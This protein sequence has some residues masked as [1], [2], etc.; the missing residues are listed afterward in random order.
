M[1]DQKGEPVFPEKIDELLAQKIVRHSKEATD[2]TD[3]NTES[4]LAT[5]QPVLHHSGHDFSLLKKITLTDTLLILS[6]LGMIVIIGEIISR[7]RR[8]IFLP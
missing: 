2:I 1:K 5:A 7:K 4:P 3:E 6:A 8:W